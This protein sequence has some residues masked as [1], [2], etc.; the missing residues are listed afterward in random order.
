MTI[1]ATHDP[2][3]QGS[4]ILPKTIVSLNDGPLQ[5][6]EHTTLELLEALS[7]AGASAEEIDRA[8]REI[9]QKGTTSL[10][11]SFISASALLALI[12]KACSNEAQ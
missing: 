10:E 9:D 11:T 5:N 1:C 6:C 2:Q 8:I 7:S 3:R 4:A 12:S